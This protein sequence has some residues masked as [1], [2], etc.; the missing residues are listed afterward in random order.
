[1]SIVDQA[2]L[3]TLQPMWQSRQAEM[4]KAIGDFSV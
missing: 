1:L 3:T 4:I 2:A